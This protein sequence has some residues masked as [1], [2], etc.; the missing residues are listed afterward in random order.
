MK[1]SA[2]HIQLANDIAP[3]VLA[4]LSVESYIAAGVTLEPPPAPVGDLGDRRGAFVTIRTSTGELRG[5]MGTVAPTCPNA[6]GEIIRNAISAATSDPRF[7]EVRT[8]ELPGLSYGVDILSEP[9]PVTGVNDLDPSRYGVIIEGQ[10][11]RRALLLP[12]IRGIDTV[13]DQWRAVHKKAGLKP[14]SFVRVERFTVRRFG[15]D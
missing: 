7:P 11:G 9:E 6:A 3:Q 13:D 4:R 15:K 2:G 12:R 10:D 5:C 8:P 14:G 1:S